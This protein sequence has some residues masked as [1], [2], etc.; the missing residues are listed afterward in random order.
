[1]RHDPRNILLVMMGGIGNLVL[2]TPAMRALRAAFPQARVALLTAERGV[3]RILDNEGLAD[4]AIC[5]SGGRRLFGLLSDLRSAR[6]DMAMAAAHTNPLKT[7]ALLRVLGIPVRIGQSIGGRNVFYTVSV[8]MS[9]NTHETDGAIALL[10][11]TGIGFPDRLRTPCLCPAPDELAD[12]RR[13]LAEHDA[14]GRPLIGMHAGS[15]PRQK[16][17]R[18]PAER[19]VETADRLAEEHGATIV[20]TGGEGEKE[21]AAGI[22]RRMRSVPVN[23]AGMLG[24]RGTAALIRLCGLFISNDSGLAHVSAAL[25]TPT[26]VLFGPT[27]PARTGPRGFNVRI[28]EACSARERALARS[29]ADKSRVINMI[30]V[31]RVAREA[32]L[33]LERQ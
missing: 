16:F 20:L 28:I 10:E 2:F 17:K 6:F 19:F 15:G 23:A 21:L 5:L 7:G 8:P 32:R 13:F 26:L 29:M 4:G 12:A 30:S 14:L 11:K 3:E 24:I 33:M 22:A 9:E 25:G 18:W 31:D 1:M 27:N